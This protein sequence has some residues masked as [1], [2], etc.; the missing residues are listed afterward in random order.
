VAQVAR[1][2][3]VNVITTTNANSEWFHGCLNNGWPVVCGFD[4]FH[5]NDQGHVVLLTAYNEIFASLVD[6]GEDRLI[7]RWEFDSHVC[8]H[9]AAVVPPSPP[10]GKP[11]RYRRKGKRWT[12]STKAKFRQFLDNAKAKYLAK[13]QPKP[14]FTKEQ[15]QAINARMNVATPSGYWRELQ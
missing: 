14:R 5:E 3:G 15:R 7:P 9:A 11:V 8:P 1:A 2:K 6:N 13:H 4:A 12:A 10:K